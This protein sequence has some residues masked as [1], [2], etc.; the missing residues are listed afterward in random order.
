M[1]CNKKELRQLSKNQLIEIILEYKGK[2]ENLE[3]RLL[4]YENAHTPPSKSKIKP[5][6]RES[7]GKLGA[8]KGHPKWEREEP[9]PTGSVEYIEDSCPDCNAKLGKPFKTERILEEEIP[10]PQPV[11]VIEHLICHYRCP[12]CRKHIVAGNKAPSQRFGKNVL[13]HVTL[14]KFDDR[15]PLRKTVCSLERHYGLKLTNVEA[16]KITNRVANKL[17]IPYKVL[18]KKIREA[19]VVYVDETEI[20]VDGVTYHLWTF[21]TETEIVFAIRKSRGND[22]LKEILGEHYDGVI[23]CDGWT[24]YTTYSS[25]LQRC[26]AHLLREAKDLAKKYPSFAGFYEAI[27]SIFKKIKKLRER[28]FSLKTREKWK[29]N[30]MLEM[31]QIIEQMNGYKEF[32]EF[33]GKIKNGFEHWFTCLIHLFVEPTNNNAERALRELIVQRKIIGGL[34]REKG[35]RIMEVIT[36]VIATTKIRQQPLFQTIKSYL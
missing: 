17:A 4:A 36:S 26:W 11:E 20:R 19:K 29:D 21:V 5:P 16:L 33:A 30:L 22:V 2:I 12:K 1:D 27:K 15:L 18:I 28:P 13:T 3:R 6:K 34:R 8:P 32:R 10:E 7:S 25:N 23:C 9:E 24:A 31:K 14:L 35:A